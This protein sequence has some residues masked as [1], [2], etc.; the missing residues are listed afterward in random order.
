[1]TDA[2]AANIANRDD[3][4]R[5]TLAALRALGRATAHEIAARAGLPR[6]EV[7]R[8]LQDLRTMGVARWVREIQVFELEDET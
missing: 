5:R 3:H 4:R 2:R 6:R 7:K 8:R 1:M